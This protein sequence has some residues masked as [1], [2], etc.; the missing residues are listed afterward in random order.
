MARV[1]E[2]SAKPVT[3]IGSTW[4]RLCRVLFQ[5]LPIGNSIIVDPQRAARGGCLGWE[6]WN[7]RCAASILWRVRWSGSQQHPEWQCSS[8]PTMQRGP[9][10]SLEVHYLWDLGTSWTQSGF[11]GSRWEVLPRRERPQVR[12]R[13]TASNLEMFV[14]KQGP[15]CECQDC[16][17]GEWLH[18]CGVEAASGVLSR[19]Q[20]WPTKFVA[21]R[22][23]LD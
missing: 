5:V 4:K 3:P 14:S 17:Q 16:G 20:R 7:K 22:A 23:D 15:K 8:A 21:T 18:R 6:C 9:E 10:H 2:L 12:K 11:D 1:A 13:D 19:R